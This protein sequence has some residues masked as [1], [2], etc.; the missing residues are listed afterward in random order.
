M[1]QCFICKENTVSS[2]E[3]SVIYFQCPRCGTFSIDKDTLCDYSSVSAN[4][5]KAEI[6]NASG[7]IYENQKSQINPTLFKK[8]KNLKTPRVTE[9]AYKLLRWLE[10][11]TAHYGDYVRLDYTEDHKLILSLYSICWVYDMRELK[12]LLFYLKNIGLIQLNSLQN[13][14]QITIS[15]EGYSHLE[16]Y[17]VNGESNIGFCAM[18]FDPTMNATWE[19]AIK[20]AIKGAGYDPKRIDK[21]PYNEGVVDEIIALIRR[22]RFVI[23]DLT[24]HRNGIYFEAGFAKGLGIEVILTCDKQ[25]QNDLHF[26]LRH[27]N[28]LFWESDKYDEFMKNLKFRIEQTIGKGENEVIDNFY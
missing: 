21:H 20:P 19:K 13:Q 22:S 23:A 3:D 15:P 2:S 18:W 6:A 8:L 16:N 11:H 5:S 12:Y 25:A 26:D 14:Q 4:F 1:R 10:K 28:F 24:G 9:K 17:L 7:W 27:F